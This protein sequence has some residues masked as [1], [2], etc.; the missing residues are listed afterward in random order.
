VTATPTGPPDA[1]GLLTAMWTAVR[2]YV[3]AAHSS[4]RFLLW[5]AAIFAASTVVLLVVFVA[6]DRPWSGSTSW[7]QPLAFS[8]A[9]TLVLASLAW[10]MTFLP[11]RRRLGWAISGTLGVAALTEVLLI[12]VQTGRQQ[13]AFFPEDHSFDGAVWTGMQIAI[14][15][16]IVAIVVEAVW[17]LRSMRAP[18]SFQWA[19]RAGLVLVV[20]GLAMGGILVAEGIRQDENNA[21]PGQVSSPVTFGDAG[22]VLVPHL[23]ALHGLVVLTVLASLLSFSAL[24]ERR[25]TRV[26][27]VA[28]AGYL[29]LV[30]VSLIQALVGRAPLDLLVPAALL[31]WASIAVLASAFATTLAG[32]R[33]TGRP[34]RA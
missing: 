30:A 23:L 33:Q 5:V 7:R 21:A 3:A 34:Q 2:G 25:R 32:L 17:A 24:A 20:A 12:A 1:D 16:I 19:T 10:V 27:Q 8:L 26:V 14:G 31:F 13:P 11:T 15:F 6:D 28:T 22:V 29:A 18:S 9:F 4:Q